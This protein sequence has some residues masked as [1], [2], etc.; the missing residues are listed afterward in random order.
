MWDD[1]HQRPFCDHRIT[2]VVGWPWH[3]VVMCPWSLAAA[4]Q[5]LLQ[6]SSDSI[7]IQCS[8]LNLFLMKISRVVHVFYAVTW[9]IQFSNSHLWHQL[10]CEIKTAYPTAFSAPSPS[11]HI[12][13][14]LTCPKYILFFFSHSTNIYL[15]P[16]ICLIRHYLL[17]LPPRNITPFMLINITIS[18]LVAQIKYL[19]VILK[20]N[21]SPIH[22]QN[23]LASLVSSIFKIY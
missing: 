14:N 15:Y 2:T 20:S 6:P 8:V 10:T 13:S 17:L 12:I 9:L 3:L 23:P 19:G 16:N 7:N 21:L 22:T 5:L 18:H 11:W 4:F 1:F